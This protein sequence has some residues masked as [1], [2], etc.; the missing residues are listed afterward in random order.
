[1]APERSHGSATAPTTQGPDAPSKTESDQDP[2]YRSPPGPRGWPPSLEAPLT[3]QQPF[4][5]GVPG[6]ACSAGETPGAAPCKA[7]SAWV[8]ERCS[9]RLLTHTAWGCLERPAQTAKAPNNWGAFAH[10]H[11]GRVSSAESKELGGAVVARKVTKADCS[12]GPQPAS[13]TPSQ[14]VGPPPPITAAILLGSG[15]AA[16]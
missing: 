16:T 7:A 6:Q 14:K 10:P 12:K 4:Q 2:T 9:L 1:M 8:G 13:L 15:A 3:G 11:K 5:V